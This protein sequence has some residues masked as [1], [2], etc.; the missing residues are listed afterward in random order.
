M[1]M[2]IIFIA[3]L[4]ATETLPRGEV[5]SRCLPRVGREGANEQAGTMNNFSFHLSRPDCDVQHITHNKPSRCRQSEAAL[6]T[7]T[8]RLC[9]SEE[10]HQ[11]SSSLEQASAAVVLRYLISPS[12]GSARPP[13]IRSTQPPAMRQQTHVHVLGVATPGGRA[14]QDPVLVSRLWALRTRRS[15]VPSVNR[16]ESLPSWAYLSST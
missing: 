3:A 15:S 5:D 4:C 11:D 12:T 1:W 16:E 2:N 6:H 10:P 14:Q 7:P 8:T 9:P 13:Q